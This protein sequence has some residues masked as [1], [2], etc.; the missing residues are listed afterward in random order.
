MVTKTMLLL[1]PGGLIRF[2]FGTLRVSVYVHSPHIEEADQSKIKLDGLEILIYNNSG[3]IEE[4]W[5]RKSG[6]FTEDLSGKECFSFIVASSYTHTSAFWKKSVSLGDSF[7]L[8]CG[9]GRSVRMHLVW[10]Y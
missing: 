9:V 2:V 5:K 3:Y 1:Q 4:V 8:S 10:Q 6:H 7:L